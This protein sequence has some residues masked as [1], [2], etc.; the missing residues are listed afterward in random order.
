E[1]TGHGVAGEYVFG[2][3]KDVLQRRCNQCHSGSNRR[4]LPFNV[5]RDER[6]KE[7]KRP[8]DVYERLVTKDDPELRYSA[9]LLLNLTRPEL[10]SLLLAPLARQA[11]GWEACG[12]VFKDTGDADYQ[13]LLDG[14]RKCKAAIEAEQQFGTPQFKPNHQ[15]IREMK[16]FGVLP[17]EFDAAKDPVDVYAT[18]QKYWRLF[19]YSPPA[20][21][22]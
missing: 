8:T 13:R 14:I 17:A 19:W 5:E 22:E 11:G 10:S 1:A 12:A 15:Y 4:P 3:Q 9:V 16:R 2:G 20:K 6:R 21:P 7:F 18:E